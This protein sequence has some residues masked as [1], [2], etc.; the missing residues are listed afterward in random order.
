MTATT[1]D[2]KADK[3]GTM[4]IPAPTLYGLPVETNTI[5]YGQTPVFNDAAGNAVD[6]TPGSGAVACWGRAFRQIDNRNSNVPYGAAGAQNIL[7]EPGAFYYASDGSVTV[8]MMGRAV[9]ALDNQTCTINAVQSMTA[10]TWLPF[11]GVVQPPALNEA[12]LNTA[13]FGKVPVFLGYPSCTGMVL[14]AN[15]PVTLANIQ[16]QTSGV[17]FNLGPAMPANAVLLDMQF[18]LATL[19]T[20]GGETGTTIEIHGGTDAAG[21]LQATTL[22]NLTS[23]TVGPYASFG[24]SNPGT[25]PYAKRGGQQLK[26]TLTQAGGTL[27][28][29]TAGAF[30]IDI[31]YAIVF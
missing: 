10:T 26:A 13:G 31:Y 4:P 2:I 23:G 3:L 19:L 22:V 21:T 28:G 8:A 14:H 30:N 7:I 6:G 16:A 20:G 1:Q 17:A 15:I 18:N 25:N 5:I 29:L 11:L 24:G 12:G 27:A 9:Y